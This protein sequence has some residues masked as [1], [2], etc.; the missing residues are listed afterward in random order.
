MA[1]TPELDE[2][3]PEMLQALDILVLSLLTCLYRTSWISAPVTLDCRTGWAVLPF[4]LK[5]AFL[6]TLL[7]LPGKPSYC[8]KKETQ[9]DVEPQTEE[10]Q[11]SRS[12]IQPSGLHLFCGLGE[13]FLLFPLCVWCLGLLGSLLWFI[14][15]VDFIVRTWSVYI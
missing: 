1:K 9:P 4:K 15:H 3:C 5:T 10:E 11:Q 13:A 8:P 14:S 7:R 2:L 12:G 6:T